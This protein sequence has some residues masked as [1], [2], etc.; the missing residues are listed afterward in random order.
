MKKNVL[1]DSEEYL[2]KYW[3]DHYKNLIK[4]KRVINNG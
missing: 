4:R 2:K 3:P 1:G